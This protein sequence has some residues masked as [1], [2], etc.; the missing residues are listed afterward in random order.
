MYPHDA[1]SEL[2]HQK[3]DISNILNAIYHCKSSKIIPN[4]RKLLCLN[5]AYNM[6]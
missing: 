3:Y 6:K 4:I 1:K 5:I 2:L